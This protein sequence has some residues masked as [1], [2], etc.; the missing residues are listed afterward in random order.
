MND[1]PCNS[2]QKGTGA[3]MLLVKIGFKSKAIT[4]DKRGFLFSGLHLR[5][6]EVATAFEK[7]KS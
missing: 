7:V 1:I 2:N 3:V 5:C 4:R 6:L